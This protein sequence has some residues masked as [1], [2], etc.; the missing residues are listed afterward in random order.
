MKGVLTN[1]YWLTDQ[2]NNRDECF[3]V[4]NAL[5]NM[6]GVVNKNG[7]QNDWKLQFDVAH[8]FQIKSTAQAVVAIDELVKKKCYS[9]AY[10]AIR[11]TIS[12]LNL[13]ILFSLNPKLFDDWLKNPKNEKYLDGH[14]R[15]ELK[16]NGIQTMPHLYE[17]SSEI[18][19]SQV[20]ALSDLG[21]LEMGLFPEHPAIEN[22][23][24][25]TLKFV[26]GM[27][28]CT[29]LNMAILDFEGKQLPDNIRQH[30]ELYNW[31]LDNYLVHNRIDQLFALMAEDRHMEKIGK[32]TYSLGGSYEF[33]V[34]AT[35]L[36]KFYKKGQ[37]K[38]LSKKYDI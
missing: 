36:S 2:F 25:V 26:I 3:V 20:E 14:V 29:V 31:F 27:V 32:D 5:F 23:I 19:H 6:A 12:R 16:N 17:F 11:T 13:L 7:H 1:T 4:V 35:Q 8:L 21:Y 33:E 22:N 18:I 30:Q 9:D 34:F 24:W 28:Y 10:G 38:K 37:K 15:A